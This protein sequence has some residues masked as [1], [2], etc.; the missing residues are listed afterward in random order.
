MSDWDS[1]PDIAAP[2]TAASGWD[3]MPD[4]G[5]QPAPVKP[6]AETGFFGKFKKSA[7][8]IVGTAKGAY[9]EVSEGLP[10]VIDA[11][12]GLLDAAA[13]PAA[14]FGSVMTSGVT[15]LGN[16]L[17]L[18]SDETNEGI[19]EDMYRRLSGGTMTSDADKIAAFE[20]AKQTDAFKAGEFA[21]DMGTMALGAGPVAGLGKGATKLGARIALRG[22]QGVMLGAP[23][24][25][26]TLLAADD[27]YGGAARA[28]GK[29]VASDAV[30]G[31]LFS[32]RVNSAFKAAS[33][34]G[35]A[36]MRLGVKAPALG[37]AQAA[38][39]A[40]FGDEGTFM[41]RFGEALPGSV[42]TMMA[43]EGASLPGEMAT[44]NRQNRAQKAYNAEQEALQPQRDMDS[45][46]QRYKDL[47]AELESLTALD[48][49]GI[50][51]LKT[52]EADGQQAVLRG[53][54][55]P[56]SAADLALGKKPKPDPIKQD[57]ARVQA[58]L[59]AVKQDL[60]S[61]GIEPWLTP[62]D[63]NAVEPSLFN[64]PDPLET[65]ARNE[66]TAAQAE[67][68]GLAR[69]P[70]GRLPADLGPNQPVDLGPPVAPPVDLYANPQPP[71]RP[72]A[73]NQP[74][75]FEQIIRPPVDPYANPQ[76][77]LPIKDAKPARDLRPV[78][79]LLM[80]RRP[81]PE[82]ALPTPEQQAPPPE[83]KDMMAQAK[84]PEAPA[85]APEAPKAAEPTPEA[86]KGR[87]V[88]DRK[89]RTWKTEPPQPTD[90]EGL[91]YLN[92]G[93]NVPQILGDWWK[94]KG[95]TESFVDKASGKEV[96]YTVDAE[97]NIKL[98]LDAK[99][100]PLAP[101]T[102]S[103]HRFW[104]EEMTDAQ[105]NLALDIASGK[106]AF[107]SDP[108]VQKG[109]ALMSI[110]GGLH[111]DVEG[112]NALSKS[113]DF[114]RDSF[115]APNASKEARQTAD[116]AREYMGRRVFETGRLHREL[117]PD[118][119]AFEK[120]TGADYDRVMGYFEGQ[121]GTVTPAE[122]AAYE[123]LRPELDKRAKKLVELGILEEGQTI[124]NY[125][126][127]A[128]DQT[129]KGDSGSLMMDTNR[130]LE[131][132]KSFTKARSYETTREGTGSG[133]LPETTN[134][135]ETQ[136]W[137]MR[138]MDKAIAGRELLNE[139]VKKGLAFK[140]G[141]DEYGDPL[142]P[143][144]KFERVQGIGGDYWVEP[145]SA[146][147]LKNMMGQGMRG[148]AL[149]DSAMAVNNAMNQLQLGMSGFHAGFVAMDSG[150]SRM[151]Q[152]MQKINEARRSKDMSY[153]IDGAKDML[154]ASSVVGPA[155]QNTVKGLDI[156]K[157]AKA[158]EITP[159]IDF[160][161][162]GGYRFE[163]DPAYKTGSIERMKES[164]RDLKRASDAGATGKVLESLT[165]GVVNT[166]LAAAEWMFKP[167]GEY[168]V[169]AVKA[170]AAVDLA[171]FELKRLGKN[172]TP[173]Q[174]R[175]A[176]RRVTDS[177][178]NRMG[179]L[180]Y[181]NLFWN[182]I[183]KDTMH[184]AQRSVGWNLGT[185]RE[186]AGGAKDMASGKFTHS[187]S[188]AL[189]LPIMTAWASMLYQGLSTKLK[190]GTAEGPLKDNGEIDWVTVLGMPKTG[191]FTPAGAE[192]RAQT[193]GY[194]SDMIKVW[195]HAGTT[196]GH[197]MSPLLGAIKQGILDNKDFYGNKIYDKTAS[198]ELRAKQIAKY[199][200]GQF[201]PF[202]VRN[203]DKSIDEHGVDPI[204]I[205]STMVGVND[206]PAWVHKTQ[207]EDMMAEFTGEKG[208]VG[209][210]DYAAAAKKE[211]K[212][213]F[214]QLVQRANLGS[215]EAL[216]AI[217]NMD[218]M[219]D[220]KTELRFLGRQSDEVRA[221]KNTRTFR[222]LS[223]GEM[224]RVLEAANPAEKKAWSPYAERSAARYKFTSGQSPAGDEAYEGIQKILGV[225]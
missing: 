206:A 32:N 152:G 220:M 201:V 165:K 6:R 136:L 207:A 4:I 63:P 200:G 163:M 174:I 51:K 164:F 135:V 204:R 106:R 97:G 145:K 2:T 157:R 99:G 66:G 27:G 7:M 36:A 40:A 217:E 3:A 39:G 208:S 95:K 205:A 213:N 223:L 178:D 90:A 28:L 138:Q 160:L 13:K 19:Q 11:S 60:T 59:E 179:Q 109:V 166:P 144:A 64:G 194:M 111:P 33:A 108:K 219:K 161:L 137:K 48:N 120:A 10:G 123:K 176:A 62:A 89:T 169:P 25:P 155:I 8:D 147:I 181:D 69:N 47:A 105:R 210:R 80:G 114:L 195:R 43:M 44:L 139:M 149:Y 196:L 182:R 150:V 21:G 225:K 146:V 34:P 142:K 118:L 129:G 35:L 193:P 84:P 49:A 26:E 61:K 187:A 203:I 177:I 54:A 197:K 132:A 170:S 76:R 18:V 192:A 202:T 96:S 9:K 38:T 183:A 141:F 127:R 12:I 116:I 50:L 16:K 68:M 224:W 103:G 46:I 153:A 185:V 175:E 191:D 133:L 172:A 151:A 87:E 209:G 189:A 214:T 215:K 14:A 212:R 30:M 167:I 74:I 94:G 52:G 125:L 1:M 72:G 188:Y 173:E 56:L 199:I 104:T 162:K 101:H 154:M 131:G 45:Q 143:P 124:E 98:H 122:K 148:N 211:S 93:L 81:A 184:L 67:Q 221:T 117:E 110:E 75:N 82:E 58:E 156:L 73:A 22:G 17:G 102:V 79:D 171:K 119:K 53:S 180:A 77:P 37:A 128:Y 70:S 159:E 42:G 107:S 41:E 198:P 112:S 186:I 65:T 20:E 222:N 86:P 140:E 158:G 126:G 29:K 55:K 24:I 78:D 83:W 121:G 190:T 115:N 71:P 216:Q 5:Q 100:D 134:F 57:L 91:Q 23:K 113:R 168:F 92:S 15:N 85:P 31:G 88:W 130:P 218:K